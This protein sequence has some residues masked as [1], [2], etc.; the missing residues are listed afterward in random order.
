MLTRAPLVLFIVY[1]PV[2]F[3]AKPPNHIFIHCDAIRSEQFENR[4]FS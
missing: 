4:H 2:I 1:F 3:P